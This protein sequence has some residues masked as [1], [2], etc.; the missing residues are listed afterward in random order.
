MIRGQHWLNNSQVFYA[1]CSSGEVLPINC[2]NK[3]YI[4]IG[5]SSLY[6]QLSC[7]MSEITAQAK[8]SLSPM[9]PRG[10][11]PHCGKV[12][13][14]AILAS[15]NR[16]PWS[17]LQA[18]KADLASRSNAK[19]GSLDLNRVCWTT[20]FRR[21]EARSWEDVRGYQLGDK[22]CLYIVHLPPSLLGS[23]HILRNQL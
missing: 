13:L 18:S 20:S 19:T 16:R 17:W 23:V 10:V 8:P 9:G 12:L 4:I 22:Y 1:R 14:V 21:S 15:R 5:P 7:L 6:K 11:V 2:E 3:I